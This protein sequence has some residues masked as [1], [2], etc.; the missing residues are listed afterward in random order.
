MDGVH[1]I[2]QGIL[3]LVK[4]LMYGVLRPQ[5]CAILYLIYVPDLILMV[6]SVANIMTVHLSVC[7]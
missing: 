4:I 5:P 6:A 1:Y 7:W 2:A 3:E